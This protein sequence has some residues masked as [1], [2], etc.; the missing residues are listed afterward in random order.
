MITVGV[1]QLKEKTSE[2]LRIVRENQDAVLI[3]Y[4]GKV[5]AKI[6]PTEPH[7]LGSE[8][9]N[10]WVTLEEL[11]VEIGRNWPEGVTSTQAMADIR[12]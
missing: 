1:R 3:T 2:I 12:R 5:V 8:S 10:A 4:H 11:A 7:A 9:E 6:S